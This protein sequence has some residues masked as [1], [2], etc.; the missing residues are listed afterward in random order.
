MLNPKTRVLQRGLGALLSG[1]R[2]APNIGASRPSHP[3]LAR[4]TRNVAAVPGKDPN[5][6][7]G[8][9]GQEHLPESNALRRRYAMT[10]ICGIIA[11]SSIL[12]AA[13]MARRNTD[14]NAGYVLV[15]DNSKGELDDV[16]YIKTTDL[17][18]S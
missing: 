14:P 6:M 13:R 10:T 16:K 17:P 11:A 8:P 12:L 3:V 7:G 1:T 2:S 15:H 18:K 4:Q 5:N 9:G